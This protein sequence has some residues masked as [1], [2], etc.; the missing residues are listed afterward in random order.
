MVITFDGDNMQDS[1]LTSLSYQPNH[2]R[3]Y[4]NDNNPFFKI[5]STGVVMQGFSI[6]LTLTTGYNNPVIFIHADN[7]VN[8]CRLRY[9]VV[10]SAANCRAAI[11][12]TNTG[13][14]GFEFVVAGSAVDYGSM[15]DL[16]LNINTR[17]VAYPVIINEPST[18]GR[19]GTWATSNYISGTWNGYKKFYIA[20]MS[21]SKHEIFLQTNYTLTETEKN[22]LYSGYV[23]ACELDIVPWDLSGTVNG[24]WYYNLL[25]IVLGSNVVLTGNS[26]IWYK[27]GVFSG[28][29]PVTTSLID[30]SSGI[31]LLR[32]RWSNTSFNSY[33]DNT[34]I[35]FVQQGNSYSM[36]AYSGATIN[37][38]TQFVE[39]TEPTTANITITGAANLFT[40][41]K[42]IT[43]ENN[44]PRWQFGAGADLDKDFVELVLNA[45]V[46]N[47][48]SNNLY[49]HLLN[50]NTKPKRIQII[51]TNTS[52]V[53]TVYESYIP[54]TFGKMI[55]K[56]TTDKTLKKIVIRFIGA[57]N[58]TGTTYLLDV[59]NQNNHRN[60]V[61]YWYQLPKRYRAY[62]TQTGTNA[63]TA[64]ADPTNF[65]SPTL[66]YVSVGKYR[67]Y[68]FGS[69]KTNK[70]FPLKA[71]RV[72]RTTGNI[73]IYTWINEN[74]YEIDTLN[75]SGVAANGIL[76]NELFDLEVVW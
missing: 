66:Q 27:Y 37:F 26:L 62:L 51:V 64:T 41:E 63:P 39:G 76:T 54:S 67:I 73:I 12:D 18:S 47:V 58:T 43:S 38:D 69:F 46:L 33:L 72:D 11:P 35:G 7:K 70:S 44:P 16:R 40:F 71:E 60:N 6:D 52:D 23:G 19:L 32:D 55:N 24:G 13:A 49:L 2:V 3:F 25:G 45:S 9:S 29:K 21:A 74:Y 42:P 10:D 15:T 1:F 53:V 31:T 65:F 20:G 34:L 75:S 14:K 8:G 22:T 61:V 5:S 28:E 59:A 48:T 17:F 30:N 57:T 36:T 50:E 56:T 68:S 4:S